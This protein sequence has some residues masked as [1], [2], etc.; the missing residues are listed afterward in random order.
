MTL[1]HPA[2]FVG[3]SLW[4]AAILCG[5]KPQGLDRTVLDRELLQAAANGDIALA[6]QSLKHGAR[7]ETQDERGA[8]PL[9]LAAKR[10]QDAMV[11]FLLEK[12]A[13]LS[14]K[15]HSGWTPLV[16]SART[17]NLDMV[18]LLLASKPDI[19]DKNQALLA[20]AGSGPARIVIDAAQEGTSN[21]ARED[22]REVKTTKL[23]LANGAQIDARDEN[24]DTP[25]IRAA[26]YGQ[27]DIVRLLLDRAANVEATNQEGQ[28]ALAAAACVC[29]M[30]TMNDTLEIEKMLLQRR[31]EIGARDKQGGFALLSAAGWGRVHNVKL[32]LDHGA[33]IE[34]TDDDGNTALI[35]ASSGS[36]LSKIDTV[37]LLLNRGA[38]VEAKNNHGDTALLVAASEEGADS[39]GIV[40]LLL[41][42]G[43]NRRAQNADGST[44]LA[45]AKQN[46][47][48][49]IVQLLQ[50]ATTRTR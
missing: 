36:A 35:I 30:A 21:A 45:L 11:K 14:A 18:A 29:A 26:G 42:K 34:T 39:I 48:D 49:E 5:C 24:G 4:I 17:G 27:T 22:S 25:L 15:D 3:T 46:G 1:H 20:A 16:H 41:S 38:N 47:R 37:R 43:A 8:T 33:D 2:L 50:K 7:I 12:G 9:I 40:K 44:P 31:S 10:S 19:A 13:N 23:L 28:S 32:L 6:Q